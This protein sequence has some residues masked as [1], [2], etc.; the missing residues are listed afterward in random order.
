MRLRR[1]PIHRK[2]RDEWGTHISGDALPVVAS[3]ALDL[4][5]ADSA[6]DGYERDGVDE[7]PDGEALVAVDQHQD[8]DA[9]DDRSEDEGD[10]TKEMEG[11]EVAL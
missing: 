4:P 8:E 2:K 9:G 7:E 5:A 3:A 6:P 1:Y 11:D 10:P